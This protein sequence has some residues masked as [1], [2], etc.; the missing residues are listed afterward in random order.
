MLLTCDCNVS[1]TLF[2]PNAK[3]T[4]V[5]CTPAGCVELLQRSG[6]EVSG[7]NAVVVGRRGICPTKRLQKEDLL[8]L[9]RLQYLFYRSNM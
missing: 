5:P 9:F 7:K 6:V 8:R 3:W 4:K 1:L 2:V